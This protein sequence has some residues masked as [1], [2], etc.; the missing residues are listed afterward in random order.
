MAIIVQYL[1]RAFVIPEAQFYDLFNGR[2]RTLKKHI[3]KIVEEE[4][5]EKVDIDDII[6]SDVPV[7]APSSSKCCMCSQAGNCDGIR[8]SFCE[9]A[10]FED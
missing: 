8:A 1:D 6:V 5:G 7:D 3:K 9:G 10:Y 2:K 4:S